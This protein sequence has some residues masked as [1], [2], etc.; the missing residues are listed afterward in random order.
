MKKLTLFI[1]FVFAISACSKAP[2]ESKESQNKR[3]EMRHKIFIE[4]MELAAKNSR[5]GDDDVSDLVKACENSSYYIV[6]SYDFT[7]ETIKKVG[8]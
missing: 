1:L 2:T 8:Q 3:A 7:D 6:N 5:Q 4:C